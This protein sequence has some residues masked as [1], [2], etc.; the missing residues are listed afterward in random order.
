MIPDALR[1]WKCAV[2]MWVQV[3]A[4][5]RWGRGHVVADVCRCRERWWAFVS[6]NLLDIERFCAGEHRCL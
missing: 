3:P 2:G 6:R 5:A 1:G 4:E